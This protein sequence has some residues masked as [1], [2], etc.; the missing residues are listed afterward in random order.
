M[1]DY[2]DKQISK[3]KALIKLGEYNYLRLVDNQFVQLMETLALL[4][5][6]EIN[7]TDPEKNNKI[8]RINE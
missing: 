3:E 6:Q 2:R 5:D 7:E 4:K 1:T 8:I